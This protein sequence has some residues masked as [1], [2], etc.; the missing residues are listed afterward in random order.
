LKKSGIARLNLN[1][2]IAED[3][4]Q[5][6]KRNA[7]V[8]LMCAVEIKLFQFIGAIDGIREVKNCIIDPKLTFDIKRG[9]ITLC[10]LSIA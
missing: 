4:A 1:N 7:T 3:V 8:F 10:K 6:L 9:I 5:S 2:Q